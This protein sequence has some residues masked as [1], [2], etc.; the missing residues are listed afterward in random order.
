MGTRNRNK[1]LRLGG[2][3]RSGGSQSIRKHTHDSISASRRH[4]KRRIVSSLLDRSFGPRDWCLRNDKWLMQSLAINSEHQTASSD[5]T[6]GSQAPRV[7][8]D[9][10]SDGGWRLD[11]RL[12]IADLRSRREVEA[13]YAEETLH[14]LELSSFRDWGINE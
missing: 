14:R 13:S 10:D 6:P 3:A 12:I 4:P 7:Y 11:L 8:T 1:R 9:R 2:A 5:V